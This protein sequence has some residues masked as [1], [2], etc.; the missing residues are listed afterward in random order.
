VPT[1]TI[2]GTKDGIARI[3]R[4]AES[5]WHQHENIESD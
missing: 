5:F 2:G 4:I 1:L 3:S